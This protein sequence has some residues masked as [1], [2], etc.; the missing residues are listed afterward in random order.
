MIENIQFNGFIFNKLTSYLKIKDEMYGWNYYSKSNLNSRLEL[1]DEQ[2][3][4]FEDNFK[5]SMFIEILNNYF[6]YKSDIKY[7]FQS[8]IYFLDFI[9]CY[10]GYRYLKRLPVR[11]QR[12]WTNAWNSYKCNTLL[13]EWKIQVAKKVYGNVQSNILN[14]LY[15]SEHINLM[16]KFQWRKEWSEARLKRFKSMKNTRVIFNIDI[17]SMSKGI[18][19]GFVKKK[20]LSKKKKDQSKKNNFTLGFNYKF[21]QYYLQLSSRLK[22]DEKNKIRILFNDDLI[23][24]KSNKQKKKIDK[25]PNK[26]IKKSLWD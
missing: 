23:K 14:M 16:W 7:Q 8:N 5:W 20:I 9:N 18:L 26:K 24:N 22:N 11:G 12:T 10:R 1:I 21:T 17:V 2:S 4:N 3:L 15:L 6:L 13:N 19:S 25:K